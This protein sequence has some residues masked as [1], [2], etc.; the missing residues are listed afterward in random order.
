MDDNKV[1]RKLKGFFRRRSRTSDPARHNERPLHSDKTSLENQSLCDEAGSNLSKVSFDRSSTGS[2]ISAATGK[3][4][5][6]PLTAPELGA[7]F[8]ADRWKHAWHQLDENSKL[9]LEVSSDSKDGN[10]ILSD[11][12]KL[13]EAKRLLAEKRAW[14]LEFA[15]RR[16]A[17]KDLTVKLVTWVRSFQGIGD[18]LVSID[19]VHAALPWAAVKLVIQVS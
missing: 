8:T 18:T 5:P 17:V 1:S 4:E 19:P 11:L 9:L 2:A 10:A 15:G 3:S 12:V 16:I 13:G 7:Q 14:K 6:P